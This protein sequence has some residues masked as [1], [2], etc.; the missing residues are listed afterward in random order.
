LSGLYLHIPF[1]KQACSYCDFYFVTRT[2]YKA[3][4]VEALQNEIK[5]YSCTGYSNEEVETIYIGGGTPSLLSI[6]DLEE[7]FD[8]LKEVFP[9]N[10]KEVTIE[11]N[12]DDVTRDY[13][14]AL[15]DLGVDRVSMGVQTFDPDRLAFMNRAHTR[16]EAQKSLELLSS[17]GFQT[18]TADL[19][20]G[21]PGQSLQSLE[22]DVQS[23]LAYNP[24]HISAYSLTV[25]PG[26]RLGKQVELGRISPPDDDLVADHFDLINRLLEEQGI[27]RYEVS[28]YSRTGH[29]AIHNSNYWEHEN[30]LGMGPAAHSF[31]WEE[32]AE[33]WS[34]KKDLKAYLSGDKEVRTEQETLTPLELAEERIMMGLRTRKGIELRE[35]EKRY[36]Y[37][38]HEK[39]KDYLARKAREGK[40]ES[41]KEIRLTDKGV[42]IADAIILD[43]ITLYP[44]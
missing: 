40:I 2:E 35:L 21:N 23:L 15:R 17:S 32:Q 19:I 24:P 43:L 38:L 28:N 41:E 31:W 6:A 20:Y 8:T 11:I 25:E 26:T 1:C 29:E 33:R 14:S 7:I 34:N 9:L 37:E 42:K 4:F 13:L 36:K 10:L 5:S 3:A 22:N 30:Y 27:R 16:R 12:P 44:H 18:F 39:Q